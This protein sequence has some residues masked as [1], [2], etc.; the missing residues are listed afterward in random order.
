VCLKHPN[1]LP[2]P[3]QR[4]KFAFWESTEKYPANSELF[5]SS[6]LSIDAQEL[7]D[8]GMSN[9]EIAELQAYY[10]NLFVEGA[11]EEK[12]NFCQ[13]PIRH[14]K[15]PDNILAP[16]LYPN[17][18]VAPFA[19]M[20]IF[21]LGAQIKKSTV[22]A[23]LAV[24]VKNKLITQQQ[25][26]SVTGFEIVRGDR[27][28]N[29][30]VLAV[31]LGYDMFNYADANTKPNDVDSRV[32]FSNFP[33]NDLGIN[34]FAYEDKE[35]KNYIQ[36]PSKSTDKTNSRY[37]FHSTTTSFLHPS[38]TAE[39]MIEGYQLG[40][41][42]GVFV[43]VENH[44]KWV[45]LASK[46][47][48]TAKTL[49][50]IEI[51]AE[52][53]AYVAD[54]TAQVGQATFTSFGTSSGTSPIGWV[55]VG[56][57]AIST[58]ANAAMSVLNWGKHRYEWET[59]FMNNGTPR[60]FAYY[61]TS[62]G[63]YGSLDTSVPMGN[64][65]RGLTVCKYLKSGK[66][67]TVERGADAR[68]FRINALNRESSVVL[69][70]G[71]EAKYGIKPP[72]ALRSYD[73]SRIDDYTSIESAERAERNDE[74]E[75]SICS[76]Y[77]KLKTYIPGQYGDIYSVKWVS[78]GGIHY[79]PETVTPEDEEDTVNIFGGDVFISRMTLKRKCPL[80]LADNILDTADMTPIAYRKQRNIGD[81][82]YY[83]NFDTSD[84]Y[85]ERS[86]F[87]FPTR[88]S[89]YEL[90]ALETS[91]KNF[92][93]KGKMY[94]Y[95]YGIPSFLVE[96][97]INLNF[98]QAGQ[99]L[100]KSFHPNVEYV[101]WTQE[102]NVPIKEDNFYKYNDVY[103]KGKSNLGAVMLPST[104]EGKID[105]CMSQKP[106]SV[107]WSNQ[108][109]NENS[110]IDPWLSYKPFDVYDFTTSL[111]KLIDVRGI[112]SEQIMARF[113]NSVVIYNAEDVLRD[114][115]ALGEAGGGMFA[116]RGR[117]YTSTDIGYMGTQSRDMV[118]CELGH[119]WV[120]AKRGHVFRVGANGQGMQELSNGM[121]NWLKENLPY[122]IL[123]YNII[124]TETGEPMTYTDFDNKF[125]GMGITMGW[126]SRF[127]R[128]FVTK[129]DY[130]PARLSETHLY[131]F[132]KGRFYFGDTEVSLT[133]KAYFKDVSF[134]VGLRGDQFISY[135][136]FTP[137][138]YIPR[139][140][141]FQTAFNFAADSRLRGIWSHLLTNRSYQVF[142]GKL[143][144]FTVENIA[145]GNYE[146]GILAAVEYRNESRKYHSENDFA[147]NRMQGFNKAYVYNNLANA[148]ELHLIP[149][150]MNDLRQEIVYPRVV[151]LRCDG[152]GGK[153][154]EILATE[155]HG[156]KWAF[157]D[158]FNQVRDDLNDIPIILR[159]DNNIGMQVNPAALTWKG[160]IGERMR[161]DWHLVRL[162]NDAESRY[163]ML[164][165]W[166]G[167][168]VRRD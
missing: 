123:R 1:A 85:E 108:D 2:F 167:A 11:V 97:E 128:V 37:T 114:R 4:E 8:A 107:I 160:T 5:D 117:E 33:Y 53:A 58:V 100:S 30:S 109:I 55:S 72:T 63:N 18:Q 13:K 67:S 139:Q 81:P 142:Y 14:F 59:I 27:T 118:S 101:E 94:L 105:A 106:N 22:K 77:M 34:R 6:R 150:I 116:Q 134:T 35:R 93:V 141:Y 39:L 12:A 131:K 70:V 119:F 147:V 144:P 50:T 163:Q 164:F 79:L 146:S 115:L 26:D 158:F 159:D 84:E 133:N 161:G 71:D 47:H 156:G 154:R 149:K 64:M 25:V 95:F 51:A 52:V 15:H 152:T 130:I 38:L 165:K 46:A 78:T 44:P 132:H 153:C 140:G 168:D 73:N 111:G 41:A 110:I 138:F 75:S 76:P 48:S 65:L 54:I 24:A 68:V 98:R 124:N 42:K 157:N 136:S 80:F 91:G 10:P 66:F 135:Y 129:R 148:G 21:P 143:Y 104:Y 88:R 89:Q 166:L 16:F 28:F 57:M 20:L 126:D 90:N 9:E 45:V 96:S 17:S 86:G 162:V 102:K 49:A 82:K 145:R 122:K 43:P 31:G 87:S 112:E 19:A 40:S 121:R 29:K 113:E 125:C 92:Y 62:E 120:D 23:F 155:T 61:Y 36:H 83:A 137:D 127:R 103:L 60:N 3:T 7:S 32:W 74:R 69:S 151:D 99:G 56:L